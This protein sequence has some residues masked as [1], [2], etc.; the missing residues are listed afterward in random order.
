MLA[1][2]GGV[3]ELK[4]EKL[5]LTDDFGGS[6]YWIRCEVEADVAEAM[7][8][9]VITSLLEHVAPEIENRFRVKCVAKIVSNF[10]TKR[11]T[12]VN[13]RFS[14]CCFN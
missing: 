11:L 5:K 2:G 12:T 4:F 14:D 8:A 3:L 10:N 9:N 6:R 1:R 13:G 7:G